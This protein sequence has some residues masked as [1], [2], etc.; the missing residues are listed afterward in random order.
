MSLESLR[1][2]FHS[3]ERSASFHQREIETETETEAGGEFSIYRSFRRIN[4]ASVDYL[5]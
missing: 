1:G 5:N 3:L 2:T 4:V